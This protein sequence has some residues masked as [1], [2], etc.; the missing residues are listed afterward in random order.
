MEN[1]RNKVIMYF[2]TEA[3]ILQNTLPVCLQ[4]CMHYN[5]N[6]KATYKYGI[7][8]IPMAHV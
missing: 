5:A 4:I 1:N 8:S 3:D 6:A 7:F 2:I